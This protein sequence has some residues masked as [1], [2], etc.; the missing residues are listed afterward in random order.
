MNDV[1]KL[2]ASD[3]I[4]KNVRSH[5]RTSQ[6]AI[7]TYEFIIERFADFLQRRLSGLNHFARQFIG[8][9]YRQ[10]S[11]CQNPC[12]G[13]FAHADATGK[14]VYRAHGVGSASPRFSRMRMVEYDLFKV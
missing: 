7:I 5:P 2:L 3:I 14:T 11:L 13:G 1:L 6:P 9:H 10:A 12:D 8:I 4:G